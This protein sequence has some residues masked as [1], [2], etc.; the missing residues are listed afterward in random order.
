VLGPDSVGCL[1]VAGRSCGRRLL[2]LGLG[3][4][5]AF[6]FFMVL[7]GW[8]YMTW[9]AKGARGGRCWLR[10]AVCIPVHGG[11]RGLRHDRDEVFWDLFGE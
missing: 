4:G 7:S 11:F 9:F 2:S 5:F 3:A 6:H 10:L 8:A 1:V